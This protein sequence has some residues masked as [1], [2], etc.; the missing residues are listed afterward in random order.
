MCQINEVVGWKFK[1]QSLA[2]SANKLNF[3]A[4]LKD[5]STSFNSLMRE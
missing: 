2:V 3:T 1:D 5:K 4:F